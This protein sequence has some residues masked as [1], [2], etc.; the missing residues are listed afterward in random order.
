MADNATVTWSFGIHA[1]FLTWLT[2]PQEHPGQPTAGFKMVRM[3]SEWMDE[4][5]ENA[6]RHRQ[7]SC[8]GRFMTPN[9]QTNGNEVQ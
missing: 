1:E 9:T 5:H 4:A 7:L 8:H 6:Q 3:Y 2:V